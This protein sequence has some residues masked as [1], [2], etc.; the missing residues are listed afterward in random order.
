[1]AERSTVT[2]NGCKACCHKQQV[3]L[4]LENGDDPKKYLVE[5][6]RTG[7]GEKAWLLKHKSNGDCIYL[8][9][10]GCTIH[11]RAPW[12]CRTFDCRRWFLGLPDALPELL[13]VDDHYGQIVKAAK[14][15]L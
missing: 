10:I 3:I 11:D 5:E 2:C 4:S 14:E 7:A 6:A 15:R 9:E 12:A 1:M 13:Q 8:G